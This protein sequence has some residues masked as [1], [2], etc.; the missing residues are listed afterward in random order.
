MRKLASIIVCAGLLVSISACSTPASSLA[1]CDDAG[2]AELVTTDGAFGA[3]PEAEFPTPLIAPSVGVT[4]NIVGDGE[5]VPSGG[6]VLSTVYVYDGETGEGRIGG[7]QTVLLPTANFAFPFSEA[8]QCGSVGSRIVTTG[9]AD[10]LFGA[11]ASQFQFEPDMSLVVVAD[12]TQGFLGRANGADQLAPS[13]MPS[14]VLAP[15]GQPGFTFSDR[16]APTELR[17]ETLKKGS[18]AKTAKDDVVVFHY[19]S[20]AWQGDS[21][22]ESTWAGA[23]AAVQLSAGADSGTVPVDV[24]SSLVGQT[25]G[26]Q[27]I[28]AVPGDQTVVYVVDILGILEQ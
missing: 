23:P 25:V 28:I 21:L 5:P 19:S 24:I 11:G 18:G 26:S 20:V 16:T 22:L 14:I 15:S 2:S 6:V 7:D 10:E 3:D 9:T 17:V 13:G 4:E 1:L 12:I 27:L 8:L